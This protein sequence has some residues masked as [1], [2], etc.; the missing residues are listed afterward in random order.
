M[1]LG[2][3][4]RDPVVA[5]Q[6]VLREALHLAPTAGLRAFE[7]IPVPLGFAHGQYPVYYPGVKV[8]H[9]R[10]RRR[11]VGGAGA[12]AGAERGVEG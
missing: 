8:E 1:G 5:R 9:G 11:C 6:Q 4:R 7:S 10:V 3:P 12:G 2:R